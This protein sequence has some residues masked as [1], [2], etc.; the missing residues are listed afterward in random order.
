M[1]SNI[2][3]P[4]IIKWNKHPTENISQ[5]GVYGLLDYRYKI[6]GATYPGVPHRKY[7]YGDLS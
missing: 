2:A 1:E 4:V 7:R 3:Q 6:S 5:A